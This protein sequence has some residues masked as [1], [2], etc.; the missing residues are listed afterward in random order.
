ML[1]NIGRRA[2]KICFAMQLSP[3][4][5]STNIHTPRKRYLKGILFEDK[6]LSHRN[7]NLPSHE[8]SSQVFSPSVHRILL[9]DVLT[10][11][12]TTT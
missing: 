5:N 9:S 3:H 11:L 4:S 6:S 12:Q 8:K 7:E 2:P 10:N 1:K